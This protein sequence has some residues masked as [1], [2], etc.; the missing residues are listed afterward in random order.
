MMKEWERGNGRLDAGRVVRK[1]SAGSRG[2]SFAKAQKY[3]SFV[4]LKQAVFIVK[5]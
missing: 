2:L 3:G 5:Q 4:T 1:T